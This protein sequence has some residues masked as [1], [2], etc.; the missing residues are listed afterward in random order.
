MATGGAFSQKLSDGSSL[1][2]ATSQIEDDKGRSYE[3]RGVP[4]D[5]LVPD[6]PARSAGEEEMV[7]E[8]AIRVLI[9]GKSSPGK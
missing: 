2:I 1:W 3:G 4:P 9:N 6:R 8:A 7:I 5:V